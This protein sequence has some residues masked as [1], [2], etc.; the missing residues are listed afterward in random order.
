MARYVYQV[1]SIVL[2]NIVQSRIVPILFDAET[3]QSPD[4][5][6]RPFEVVIV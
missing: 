1:R 3:R 5:A 2:S 4:F 6:H